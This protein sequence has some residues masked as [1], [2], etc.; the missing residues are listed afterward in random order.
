M[1]LTANQPRVHVIGDK[2]EL[3]VAASLRIFQGA[4]VGE[5]GTGYARPLNA[6]DAFCG[7]AE[8]EADN[9]DGANGEIDVQLKRS[10][11]IELD[12]VGADVTS[13]DQPPVY[14]SDDG[15][16]TLTASTN[17]LIGYVVRHIGGTLC[18][19]AYDASLVKAALQA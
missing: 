1:A 14:A 19:V 3:P 7:F 6:G 5:N 11:R 16:F 17:S 15:T 13:N 9:R 18:D 8:A 10:G 2:T 4:A 12:V